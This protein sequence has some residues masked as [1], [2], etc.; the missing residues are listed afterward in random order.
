MRILKFRAF[1]RERQKMRYDV[2]GFEH[3]V[4]NEMNIIFCDGDPFYLA[5]TPVMQFIGLV[6]ANKSQIYEGDLVEHPSFPTSEIVFSRGQFIAIYDRGSGD[7]WECD[8]WREASKCKVI[9][10]IYENADLL[11]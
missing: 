11:D 7:E 5:D 3:G 8:F 10:N 6:D 1:D 2:T 4:A 9:G